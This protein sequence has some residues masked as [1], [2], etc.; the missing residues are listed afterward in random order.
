[1]N[2]DEKQPFL[3]HLEELRSR[4]IKCAISIGVGFI[5]SYIFAEDLFK[6]LISP[7]TDNLPEGNGLIFTNLPEMFFTYLKTA[8]IAGILLASPIIFYQIWKFVAPGLYQNEKRYIVPFVFFSTILFVGG[9]LGIGALIFRTAIH[10][11]RR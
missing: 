9:A 4:L 8:F 10:S 2:E 6:I 7:L 11:C 5:I 3:S 1:M